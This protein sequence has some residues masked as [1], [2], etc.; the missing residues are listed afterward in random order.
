[1]RARHAPPLPW[2][3]IA[4]IVLTVLGLLCLLGGCGAR[5]GSLA[6]FDR[7]RTELVNG[8]PATLQIQD[9]SKI[10]TAN[11]PGPARYT[12]VTDS[13]VQT[14]QTGSTPRDL[15][16]SLPNGTRLVLSS[17]TD[18]LAKGV[19]FNPATN[20][21]RVAEFGTSASEPLRALERLQELAMAYAAA[22]DEAS[23]EAIVA[24]IRAME[25]TA[26]ALVQLMLKA[27]G[28]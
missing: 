8:S 28:S 2:V 14:I 5:V 23:K 17:G 1:M 16:F 10:G 11:G 21:L 7:A 9:D 20:M 12:S 19:E 27:I 3:L 24:Q 4:I 13:G 15:Y 22:R 25:A 26:P 18:I 6:T